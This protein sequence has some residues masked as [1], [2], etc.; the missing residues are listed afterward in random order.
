MA[1]EQKTLL[2]NE[3]DDKEKSRIDCMSV[4]QTKEHGENARAEYDK[5][6][7]AIP[8]QLDDNGNERYVFKDEILDM[9]PSE[10]KNKLANLNATMT[11][12]RE[13]N[14]KK[15]EEENIRAAAH[16][17]IPGRQEA[18]KKME[19]EN[20]PIS[21]K[22][23]ADFNR[24]F[25]GHPEIPQGVDLVK[26]QYTDDIRDWYYPEVFNTFTTGG[27][28]SAGQTPR[29]PKAT[30]M[31]AFANPLRGRLFDMISK[32]PAPTQGSEFIYDREAEQGVTAVTT[33]TGYGV[34]ENAAANTQD[35][36]FTTYTQKLVKRAI[37][38][39]FS[40]ESLE[41]LPNVEANI[42]NVMTR[43]MA[44]DAEFG[45]LRGSE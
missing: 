40:E 19:A 32:V 22:D 5:I 8:V 24:R 16:Q 31:V 39:A 25:Y 7:A 20:G 44:E 41:D 43:L 42:D 2:F 21:F 33:G 13:S 23:L 45:I 17:E 1:N 10:A 26:G 28:P 12:C 3:L 35:V 15:L 37:H 36:G 30:D 18:L 9:S 6:V 34:A 11:H 27:A 14:L 4:E 29:S 38:T